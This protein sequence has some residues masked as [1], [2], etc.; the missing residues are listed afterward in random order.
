MW[1]AAARWLIACCATSKPP[2]RLTAMDARANAAHMALGDREVIAELQ[3]RVMR[4]ERQNQEI[5]LT[6]IENE[7]DRLMILAQEMHPNGDLFAVLQRQL[8]LLIHDAG[9]GFR[10]EVN[11]MDRRHCAGRLDRYGAIPTLLKD[12]ILVRLRREEFYLSM[13]AMIR[14]VSADPG[15]HPDTLCLL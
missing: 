10:E 15:L 4:L 9:Y 12:A 11:I 8:M 5:R 1:R 3:A 6:C 2:S 14:R 7:W 13:R